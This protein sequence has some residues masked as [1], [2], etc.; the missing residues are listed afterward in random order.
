MAKV[1]GAATAAIGVAATALHA[2]RVLDNDSANIKD[3]PQ[4]I[5]DTCNIETAL[6]ASDDSCTCFHRELMDLTRHTNK[7]KT[8]KFSI[9]LLAKNRVVAFTSELNVC[10]STVGL[11]LNGANLQVKNKL[12]TATEWLTD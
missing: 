12:S 7:G 2:I 1:F 4:A 5:L 8:S 3:A 9:G 11:A 6:K 10:K